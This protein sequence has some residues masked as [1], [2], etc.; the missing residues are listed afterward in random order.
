[1]LKKE[2]MNKNEIPR[3]IKE[4]FKRVLEIRE[5]KNQ[6]QMIEGLNIA[7]SFFF[8]IKNGT[9]FLSDEKARELA[10]LSELP[11]DYVLTLNNFEKC[12]DAE[13]KEAYKRILSY[14]MHIYFKD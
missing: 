7:R 9:D 5:F 2:R 13:S 11:T 8:R 3:S 14:L 1:M 4:V 6:T 10:E 12:K